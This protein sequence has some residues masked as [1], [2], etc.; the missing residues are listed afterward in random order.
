MTISDLLNII[1]THYH[2]IVAAILM[3]LGF[4][5]MIAQSNLIKKMIGLSIFQVSILLMYIAAGYVQNAAVPIKVTGVI[6]Y[7]NPVPHVLMLTAI[8]VG[9]AVMAVGLAMIIRIKET[10][11]TI[12]EDH[13]I[14]MDLLQ[15]QREKQSI[16]HDY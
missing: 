11:K 2:Y 6:H 10:Y 5:A 8:V 1:A 7:V 14:R 13:M 4:Y 16:N 3:M 9:V 12:E 15:S